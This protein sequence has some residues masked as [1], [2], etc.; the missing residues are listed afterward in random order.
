MTAVYSK[1]LCTA[2]MRAAEPAAI[3]QERQLF[4]KHDKYVNRNRD[5]FTWTCKECRST[6][7]VS[8]AKS[9]VSCAA[10]SF[11][12]S[13]GHVPKSRR[14]RLSTDAHFPQVNCC[15]ILLRQRTPGASTSR[16]PLHCAQRISLAASADK[17]GS[18]DA[19]TRAIKY[20]GILIA[21]RRAI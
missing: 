8:C 9:N 13:R 2:R 11:S 14:S 5:G 18:S 3:R 7:N 16:G 12:S 15:F 17:I 10:Q 1:P 19:M 20:P 4:D 6:A 21:Q